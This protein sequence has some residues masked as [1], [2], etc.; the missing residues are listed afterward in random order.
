MVEFG[1]EPTDNDPVVGVTYT[2]RTVGLVGFAELTD[3]T[4]AFVR[5]VG[6]VGVG[7]VTVP[8]PPTLWPKTK[9]HVPTANANMATV[10]R[11]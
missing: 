8:L 5:R 9:E 4:T 11:C 10:T 7:F 3:L 2:V 6:V 1:S